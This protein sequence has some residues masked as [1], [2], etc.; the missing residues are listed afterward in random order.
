VAGVLQH[1]V[2]G[3]QLLGDHGVVIQ[4]QGLALA[5]E[6]VEGALLPG[7]PDALLGQTLEQEHWVSSGY[8]G[9]AGFGYPE[10]RGAAPLI[11]GAAPAAPHPPQRQERAISEPSLLSARDL[12]LVRPPLG[13][14]DLDLAAGTVTFLAG[15]SGSGKSRLLRA[16]ADLDRPAGGEIRLEG[17]PAREYG[18]PRY[19]GRVAYLPATPQLGPATV[20]GLLDRVT[21]LRHRRQRADPRAGLER[22][23]LP[24]AVL[25][26]P[27][28]E[29]S[30]GETVR[31]ALAL[32]LSGDARVLLLDE[33]T[34]SLD[35]ASL[36]AVEEWVRERI[37]AGAAVLWVSHD[38]EQAARLGDALLTLDSGR[39]LGPERD[40]E[41][42]A[43]KVSRLEATT[44]TP[45][46]GERHAG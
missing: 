19:R 28:E 14:L 2:G 22:L 38:P 45:S 33:P 6:V 23:G 26:R 31:V 11:I 43:E 12:E 39:L 27:A 13:P 29:L 24:S 16:L 4:L 25:E 34:G 35:P 18:A 3:A 37:E 1:A 41:R 10:P 36:R 20:A 21:A 44:G 5:R 32:V 30:T 15:A 42:F 17:R 8:R 40:R 7:F 46:G 9:A